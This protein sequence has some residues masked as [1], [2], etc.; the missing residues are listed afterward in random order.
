RVGLPADDPLG[1]ADQLAAPRTHH[2]DADDRAVL[3]PD[4]L[5]PAGRLED[6][7]LAVAAEVVHVGLDVPVHL[8]GLGFGEADGRD[9]R[10]A[11]GDFRD[12]LVGDHHGV[13]P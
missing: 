3:D 9:V 5:D 8:F 10:I 7:R 2:V 1:L 13:Q 11:V 4:D 12:L 6:L